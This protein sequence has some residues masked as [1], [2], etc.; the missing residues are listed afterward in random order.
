MG[1]AIRVA[2]P[3][4]NEN[5]LKVADGAI[6][7]AL[8]AAG[9][10]TRIKT[11]LYVRTADSE[12]FF[13]DAGREPDQLR[14]DLSPAL[15]RIREVLRSNVVA[16]RDGQGIEAASIISQLKDASELLARDLITRDEFDQLKARLID[17]E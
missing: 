8:Q 9:T 14:I 17:G 15:G 5:L 16:G 3:G 12:L 10:R 11:V 13:L 4:M 7:A 1:A 2:Q 6:S